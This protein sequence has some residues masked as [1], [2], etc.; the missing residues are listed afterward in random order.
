MELGR[1]S[2]ILLH[3]TSLPGGRLGDE[4]YRFVDWLAAAG[5]SWWQVLP[6]GPP[7]GFGSPYRTTSAFAGSPALL[8]DPHAP[9]TA[10]EI[11]HFVAQRPYWTGEW[12]RWGTLADQVRFQREWTAL[13]DYARDRGIRLI[14]DV[15]I[16]VSDE[17]ADIAAWPELFAHGDVAGAPPDP[18]NAN[19]QHWGNPLYDWAQHRRTGFRWWIERFARTFELVDVAR[20]DHFR[21]FVAYWSIPAGLKT[22][23]KGRWRTAPGLE[24]FTTIEREL[25]H[26]SLIAEDLG[27][28]TPAVYRL[29]DELGLPGIVVL[30]WAFGGA[31]TNVHAPKNHP[32]RA[33]VY[34]GTHDTDT[35]VGWYA[36]LSRKSRD[37]TGLDPAEPNWN[38][39]H[40]A[41]ESRAELAIVPV[42]DVLGLGNEARMNNPGHPYGNWRW[43]LAHGALTDAMAERLR[44]ETAA[45]RRL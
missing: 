33:V 6:L 36:S 25:G 10:D 22:A 32:R 30:Q 39:I 5:Q 42:Q 2:G 40:I 24:L 29:R 43:Q 4:A 20:I 17:G 16:Y 34:T 37:A 3:P 9:V 14:G 11:E 12:A 23:R 15:P 41:M 18:L 31:P 27:V 38:L 19:G 26:L 13:R 8:A 44:E 45:G 21:G 1:S 28:I 35:T 7:D